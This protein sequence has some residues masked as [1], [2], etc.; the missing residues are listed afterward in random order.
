VPGFE[1]YHCEYNIDDCP[2][3]ACQNGGQCEDLVNSYRCLCLTHFSGDHCEI[4]DDELI[5]KENVSRSFSVFA[6][7]F[8]F[9]TYAF[10]I[11]LDAMRFVLKIE[12]EGLSEERDVI[13]KRRLL[14]KL[15][16]ELREQQKLNRLRRKK[17]MEAKGKDPFIEKFEKTFHVSY[18]HLKFIDDDQDQINEL[19][20]CNT[21]HTERVSK[22]SFKKLK[23]FK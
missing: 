10:F 11:S 3:D 23:L 20:V 15:L 19:V 18:N 12:P 8:I 13:R 7:V 17:L 21:D 1:G 9:L 5:L 6:I 16:A 22:K 14:K 4:K 2:P